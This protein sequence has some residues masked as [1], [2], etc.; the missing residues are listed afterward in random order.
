M[1]VVLIHGEA[2]RLSTKE[3]LEA[4]CLIP[5][6]AKHLLLSVG[7]PK[8]M[9]IPAGEF[10]AEEMDDISTNSSVLFPEETS[11]IVTFI[12]QVQQ[13]WENCKRTDVDEEDSKELM[14]EVSVIDNVEDTNMLIPTNTASQVC[15]TTNPLFLQLA[16]SYI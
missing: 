1:H 14:Q 8:L 5:R 10:D 11:T 2:R 13:F 3:R 7:S 6:S 15:Q 4:P 12:R 16:T 9:V